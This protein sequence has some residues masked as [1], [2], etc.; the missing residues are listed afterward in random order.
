VRRLHLPGVGHGERAAIVLA[1]GPEMAS[2]FLAIGTGVVTT[3][4]KPA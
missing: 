3:L 4:R 2:A 1:K